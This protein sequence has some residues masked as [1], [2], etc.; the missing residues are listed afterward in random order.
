MPCCKNLVFRSYLQ[1]TEEMKNYILIIAAAFIFCGCEQEAPKEKNKVQSGDSDQS[2]EIPDTESAVNRTLREK[3]FSNP[4]LIFG[5]SF[6]D[7]LSQLRISNP[8][9]DTLIYFTSKE[10]V[11]R[12]G[13]EGVINYYENIIVKLTCKKKLK[14]VKKVGDTYFL[15][16][17]GYLTATRQNMVFEVRVENDSCKLVCSR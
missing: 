13:K 15:S 17:E 16:Y 7:F 14:A 11:K 6:I 9:S 4:A 5:S 3:P 2:I 10:S 1:E 12:L 8:C